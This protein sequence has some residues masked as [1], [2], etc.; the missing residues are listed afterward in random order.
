M[1]IFWKRKL[2]RLE[3]ALYTGIIAIAVAVFFE[4]LLYYMEVAERTAMMVTVS[5]VNSAIHLGRAVAMLKGQP[6]ES[7]AGGD[8]FELAGITPRNFLGAVDKPVL[9]AVERG[10]WLFDRAT[11]EAIYLPRLS[12]QLTT[13]DP[14]RVIRF[15][16]TPPPSGSYPVLVPTSKYN[17]GSF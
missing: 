6:P 8:P 12:R 9:E 2:T 10:V 5:Q 17:W 4:R 14:N 16:L 13:D 3:L 15:R 1:Q 11:G 7:P